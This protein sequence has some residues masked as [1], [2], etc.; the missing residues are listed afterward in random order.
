[1]GPFTLRV[2]VGIRILERITTVLRIRRPIYVTMDKWIY[3]LQPPYYTRIRTHNRL[4]LRGAS[5][6][7]SLLVAAQ[8][9]NVRLGTVDDPA[10]YSTRRPAITPSQRNL[11][12]ENT[13][14]NQM[15]NYLRVPHRNNER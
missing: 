9:R 11:V 5:E 3:P 12:L 10:I 4:R 6:E 2:W 13:M 14:F 8:W 7:I 15:F 1:M